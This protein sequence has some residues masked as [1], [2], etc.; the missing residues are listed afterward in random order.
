[1]AFVIIRKYHTDHADSLTMLE[2]IVTG[3]IDFCY[4]NSVG[5]PIQLPNRIHHS[6]GAI[7]NDASLSLGFGCFTVSHDLLQSSHM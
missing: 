7:P 3:N 1:M 4:I 5:Y 6:G 2:T